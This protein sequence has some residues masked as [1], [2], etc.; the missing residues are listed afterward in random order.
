[1]R[2]KFGVIVVVV[3]VVVMGLLCA[4]RDEFQ[5]PRFVSRLA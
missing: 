1:V 4:S 5:V 2:A 3:V